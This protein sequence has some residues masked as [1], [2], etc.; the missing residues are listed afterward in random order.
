MHFNNLFLHRLRKSHS[1]RPSIDQ[2]VAYSV[3]GSKRLATPAVGAWDLK[4]STPSCKVQ[5][6]TPTTHITSEIQ[7]DVQWRR[8]EEQ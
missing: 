1:I 6:R 3:H 7:N 4:I 2:V 8:S 5:E